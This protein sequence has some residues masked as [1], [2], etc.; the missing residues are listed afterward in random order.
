MR[1]ASLCVREVG[2]V[3]RNRYRSKRDAQI[4]GV[5]K[6]V[7]IYKSVVVVVFV[8]YLGALG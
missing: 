3:Q 7:Q 6:S 4:Y 8:V 5:R 2:A 1:R